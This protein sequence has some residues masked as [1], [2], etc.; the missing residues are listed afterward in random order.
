[1]A[2][3]VGALLLLVGAVAPPDAQSLGHWHELLASEPHVAGT[4]G[5]EREIARLATAFEEMGLPTK[6]EPF[7]ALLPQPVSATLEI[8]GAEAPVPAAPAGRRRGVLSLSLR[9]DNLAIDPDAAHP[10]L[11]WG[12]NAYSA[13]GDVTAEVVYASYGTKADFAK[14]REWGVDCTGKIVIARYGGNFR[15]FKAKFA[16]EAGAAG[17]IMFTDPADGGFTRGAVWPQGGWANDSCVQRGS[18]HVLPYAGDPLT[19]GVAA[20]AADTPR[21]A[22]ADVALPRIPVQPIGYRAAAEILSRMRGREVPDAAWRG[23]LEMPYRLEGG[24]E[25]KVHM[26]IEQDREIRRSAN[27]VARIEGRDD[28]EVI[29]GCHHDAWCF[30]AADPLAGTIVLMESART[31]ADKARTGWTPEH[32]IVFVAWGAEEYGMVGSGEWVEAHE[33]ELLERAIAYI[34][35]DMAAMGTDLSVS[36]T[37]CLREL[38]TAT[39]RTLPP[40]VGEGTLFDAWR[41]DAAEPSIG[42]I[43]GGS[44]HVGF[45]CR[46]GVPSISLGAGGAP[47]TSY[48]S[49]Y[50]TVAWYRSTVGPGYEGALMLT[51]L[52]N[53]LVERLA[54]D[55]AG[56]LDPAADL[57]VVAAQIAALAKT[58]AGVRNAALLDALAQR[59]S[60]AAA[61][62]RAATAASL[63]ARMNACRGWL[64]AGGLN[65]RPWFRNLMVTSDPDHGYAPQT[66]PLLREAVGSSN[67]AALQRAVERMTNAAGRVA[68]A[69]TPPSAAGTAGTGR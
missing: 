36:A 8:V 44:D 60:N 15:G 26:H 43:G 49:N 18:L 39:T 64:D 10:D 68:G 5:D 53:A 50:D 24:A 16:Q 17:L 28:R 27:V 38:V 1:M 45:V 32:D 13:S 40:A 19:P 3:R 33:A 52:C 12:W 14:L 2:Q 7:W 63:G 58:E 25:L 11:R 46:V 56:C 55:D 69:I 65:G 66:L 23:G 47:G 29:V 42:D 57:E 6:V 51:R 30:G 61:R 20:T 67:T 62:V 4:P 48:H 9:E 54:S 22:L 59:M 31:L 21:A 37:P 41:K 35:L 34:N